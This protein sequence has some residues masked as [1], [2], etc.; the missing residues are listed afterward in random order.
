MIDARVTDV[1]EVQVLYA[2]DSVARVETTAF[3]GGQQFLKL[4]LIHL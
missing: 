2:F 4:V 3:V 1:F